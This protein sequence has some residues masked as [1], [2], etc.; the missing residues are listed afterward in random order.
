MRHQYFVYIMASPSRVIYTG[1]TN[2]VYRRAGQHRSRSS[3]GS[4]TARHNIT[5]LVYFESHRYILNAIAREKEIKGWRREKKLRL[6]ESINPTWTDLTQ[7]SNT[8]FRSGR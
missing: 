1:V 7:D 5:R 6:I 8:L 2:D 3:P 4:F